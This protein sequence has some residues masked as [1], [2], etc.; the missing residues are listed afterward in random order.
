MSEIS[1]KKWDKQL[2]RTEGMKLRNFPF[3]IVLR[4]LTVTHKF[5]HGRPWVSLHP[6]MTVRGGVTIVFNNSH[7]TIFRLSKECT[8]FVFCFQENC[9]LL[10]TSFPRI[11]RD[12][13]CCVGPTQG[14]T[15]VSLLVVHLQPYNTFCRDCNVTRRVSALI[16]TSLRPMTQRGW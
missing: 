5:V 16:V 10:T 3:D 9:D 7:I 15:L 8:R 1:G 12:R 11:P 14:F 4:T 6:S 2:W 13:L